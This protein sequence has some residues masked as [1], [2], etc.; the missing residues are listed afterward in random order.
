MRPS[1]MSSSSRFHPLKAGRRLEGREPQSLQV[2][3]F[4]SPQGGSETKPLRSSSTVDYCFHPL[5]A[6]RRRRPQNIV[7]F[8]KDEFPSPQGG[9][10]TMMTNEK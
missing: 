10:E 2:S 9:S 4:P 6:G 1:G 8:R 5:K 3:M 7:V